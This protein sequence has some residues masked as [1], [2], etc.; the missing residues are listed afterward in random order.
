MGSINPVFLLP[1][2]LSQSA[3]DIAAMYAA[4]ITLSVGQF[5]T[6]PGLIIGIKSDALNNF[7]NQLGEKIKQIAPAA[8]LHQGIADAYVA[9]KTKA[10]QQANVT[11]VA[12]STQQALPNQGQPT[13]ATVDA[14]TFLTNKLLHEEVFG[15]YSLIVQCADS[16]EMLTVAEHVEGQLTSTVMATENDIKQ[17]DAL[18]GVIQ[19]VCGRIIMNG[20]PTG[21]EVCYSMQHGGPFPATTDSRFTSVGAD[22][23]KRFARPM[24][25]QNWPNDL[26]PDELKNNNPLNIWRMVNNEWT[27]GEIF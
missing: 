4:S 6:N 9:K 8:M 21:V 24:S 27:K 1:E 18:V 19:N 22:G 7:I 16:N 10:L 3:G 11:T 23:I 15:P 2:K 25:F 12:E 5:C 17:H 20:V 26:L 14:T 13:I